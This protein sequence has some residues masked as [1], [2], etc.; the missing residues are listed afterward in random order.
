MMHIARHKETQKDIVAE[1]DLPAKEKA[2]TLA[3]VYEVLRLQSRPNMYRYAKETCTLKDGNH[4]VSILKGQ[5]VAL[6]PRMMHMD[7][8]IHEDPSDF[9]CDR[10]LKQSMAKKPPTEKELL[11]FGQGRGAC[12]ANDYTVLA[13]STI[14]SSL[15]S[16]ME[17]K[18]EDAVPQSR[19]NTVASTPPPDQDAIIQ[20]KLC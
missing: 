12:P 13:L 9:K 20:I 5:W 1:V 3:I 10:F 6:F 15:L 17:F 8:E 4:A 11:V 18:Y 2:K 7:Q 16:I 19:Q 14:I